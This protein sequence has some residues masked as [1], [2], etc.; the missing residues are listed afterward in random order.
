MLLCPCDLQYDSVTEMFEEANAGGFE[1]ADLSWPDCADDGYFT[2]LQCHVFGCYC[3]DRHGVFVE[4]S[5]Q[6]G[7]IAATCPPR[8]MPIPTIAPMRRLISNRLRNF[9]DTKTARR[10]L[11]RVHW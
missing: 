5:V 1:I 4:G 11:F 3:V 8:E 10:G 2:P 7:P 9:A 6:R